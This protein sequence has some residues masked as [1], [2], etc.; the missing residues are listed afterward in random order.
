MGGEIKVDLSNEKDFTKT[1]D[2]YCL[3]KSLSCHGCEI[4]KLIGIRG[5]RLRCECTPWAEENKDVVIPILQE[6]VDSEP[7]IPQK[8]DIYYYIS[9]SGDVGID[10]FNANTCDYGRVLTKNCF[11]TNI[12]AIRNKAK[13]LAKYDA[14]NNGKWPD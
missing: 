10:H 2:A 12:A 5:S 11:R 9:A 8:D 3:S 13:V 1:L 6:W 14:I 7:F 4:A